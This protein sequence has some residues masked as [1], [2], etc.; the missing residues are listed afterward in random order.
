MINSQW[1][2]YNSTLLTKSFALV[3]DGQ[4]GY[5][6]R[7]VS[8]NGSY[9]GGHELE[10]T[11][12]LSDYYG[13]LVYQDNFYHDWGYMLNLS[14]P[15]VTT[16]TDGIIYRC[17]IY[18][19]RKDGSDIYTSDMQPSVFTWYLNRTVEVADNTLPADWLG[20]GTA[21]FQNPMETMTTV[22]PSDYEIDE[23][24]IEDSLDI[25]QRILSAMGFVVG[26]FTQILSLRYV[27]FMICFGLVVGLLGWFL[28]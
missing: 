7:G 13:N 28:H 25:P 27:T 5:S 12:L 8:F 4:G 11:V 9:F 17:T 15:E 26:V 20:T 21:A 6:C 18:V 19:K 1:E 10:W 24:T 22:V 14:L 3:G 16:N 2:Y 23:D